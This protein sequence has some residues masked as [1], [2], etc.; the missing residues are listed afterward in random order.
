MF[1]SVSDTACPQ[2]TMSMQTLLVEEQLWEERGEEM[3]SEARAVV[4]EGACSRVRLFVVTSPL[5]R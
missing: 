2:V 5:C 3:G 4:G 1:T